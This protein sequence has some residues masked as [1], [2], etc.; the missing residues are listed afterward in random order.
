MSGPDSDAVWREV[1]Q[2]IAHAQADR[3]AAVVCLAADPPLP[4]VVAFHCQQAAEKL[5][6]GFLVH[7]GKVVRKTHDLTELGE[8]V[9]AA[10]PAVTELICAVEAWTIWNIAYRYPAEDVS[11]APP[12]VEELNSALEVIG[13][14][15]DALNAL[16]GKPRP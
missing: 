11:D 6:K 10:Y 9:A 8:A 3:R 4:D 15:A 16:G 1:E 7:A 12:S 13:R 14:L 5:L 2:W